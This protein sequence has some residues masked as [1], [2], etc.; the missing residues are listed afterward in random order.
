MGSFEGNDLRATM[1]VSNLDA[2][3]RLITVNG[4]GHSKPSTGKR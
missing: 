1:L 3:V 2:I 4:G